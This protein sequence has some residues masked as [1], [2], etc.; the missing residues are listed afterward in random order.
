MDEVDLEFS[1]HYLIYQL[2][3]NLN[4]ITITHVQHLSFVRKWRNGILSSLEEDEGEEGRKFNLELETVKNDLLSW[5]M[6]ETFHLVFWIFCNTS[7]NLI[8]GLPEAFGIRLTIIN[9][10]FIYK[11]CIDYSV[12][13]WM[14]N[15][16]VFLGLLFSRN[17]NFNKFLFF[18]HFFF[19]HC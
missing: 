4:C 2:K 13:C 17:K 1:R 18:F 10:G 7:I 5:H 6:T 16:Y 15:F 12:H 8:P 3:T 9:Q 11:L 14:L 19:I